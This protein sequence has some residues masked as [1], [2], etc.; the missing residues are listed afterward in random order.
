MSEEGPEGI[1][2]GSGS[3]DFE[4]MEPPNS[5]LSETTET[6]RDDLPY[7][8]RRATV[9]SE[10][11]TRLDLRVRSE[12]ADQESD[13]LDELAEEFQ[14]NVNKIDLREAALKFAYRNPDAIASVLREDGFHLVYGSHD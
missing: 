6:R 5:N 4:S 1:K 8:A 11:D 2:P 12:V 14:S 3:L 13:V 7:Y 10:R 9:N